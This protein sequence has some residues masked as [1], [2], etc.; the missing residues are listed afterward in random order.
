GKDHEVDRCSFKGFGHGGHEIAI[1][2]HEPSPENGHRVH[3]NHFAGR[4]PLGRNG[5]ETIYIGGSGVAHLDSRSVI[6]HNL[7]E[8]CDGEGEIITNKSC[9]NVYRNN[10]FRECEGALTLRH[11]DRCTVEGNFFL[12][13]GKPDTGGVRVIGEG[14]T[15]TH[16]YFADLA[17]TGA[18][19]ALS[20]VNGMSELT[21][22][23][24]HQVVNARVVSNTFV[25]CHSI[26]VG[27]WRDKRPTM[28]LPPRNCT[29]ARNIVLGSPSPAISIHDRPIDMTWRSN[30]VWDAEPGVQA[31]DG[32]TRE[33]PRLVADSDGV[34]RPPGES[35]LDETEDAEPSGDTD[36]K[37]EGS[38]GCRQRNR[39]GELRGPLTDRDVGPPW[40]RR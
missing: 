6:E 38:I 11:G 39:D 14:H 20:M 2:L 37:E 9:E 5:A 12:G 19:S 34:L 17:G 36:G 15:V 21:L 13:N 1:H 7:F 22:G 18:R 25:N 29:F 24:Y 4:P 27:L 40:M 8:H 28:T 16:N 26:V 35:S 3:H 33:D 30:V 32:F 10:T 23:G 31:E